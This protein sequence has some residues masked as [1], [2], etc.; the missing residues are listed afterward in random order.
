[1]TTAYLG[2][3]IGSISTK[4]VL[5]DENRTIIARSYL[6]TEGNP[7]DAARRVIADLG[8]QVDRAAVN[9][10]TVGTT[11]SARRLV[12]AMTNAVVIKN[13]ITAHAVGTT[14]LHP[15]ARTILEIGGQDSKIICIE[16]GIAV[17]Y[18]MNTLC[19]AGTGAF[20]SSQ[21]HRLG[22]DVEQFG[23]I[24]LTSKRP[25]NIAARCTVFAESDLV[26]KIQMGYARE[27][28]IAGLCHA[29]ATNYLNN[30]GKG[31]K[32]AAPVVF[33]GGVSKNVGVVRAFEEALGMDVIVDPDGH[34]MGAFGVAILAAE[35][36]EPGRVSSSSTSLA[37]G[38]ARPSDTAAFSFDAIDDFA[39]KTRE[40]E[41]QK[42]ANHCEIICVYRD[43]TLID[44]WG[45]R[46]DQGVMKTG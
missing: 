5:I 35:A 31:K 25:A 9:V 26:H 19:A 24:A 21:A 20:L 11:G 3:D 46:C 44:S 12:G 16:G 17:D 39:F 7:T 22:V 10:R 15:D 14:Y 2:I 40:V 13:E 33:Q 1:M 41:C 6:W 38:T 36:D 27:D 43:N 29:V 37:T 45:N 30:V 4:G 34:L 42:C 18:A 28:I 8:N 23:E 32:I